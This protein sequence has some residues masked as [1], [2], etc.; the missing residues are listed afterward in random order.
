MWRTLGGRR[1][2]ELDA[3]QRR[4]GDPLCPTRLRDP[5]KDEGLCL[6]APRAPDL[7]GPGAPHDGQ[8]GL[9]G[10]EAVL[11]PPCSVSVRIDGVSLQPGKQLVVV[12]QALAEM[13]SYGQMTRLQHLDPLRR[14]V[15][16]A[17]E[18]FND[19]T[20]QV[21]RLKEYKEDGTALGL[22]LP[23]RALSVD[24]SAASPEPAALSWPVLRGPLEGAGRLLRV[25]H[26]S[27][28]GGAAAAG[29]GHRGCRGW[30]IP[31]PGAPGGGSDGARARSPED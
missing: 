20:R 28:C 19:N 14:R 2:E 27:S 8:A 5:N 24:N 23:G 29:A 21:F 26:C 4:R 1:A 25:Y 15:A 31:R 10:R 30:Q 3:G 12:R 7:L 22:D 11:R 16:P 13:T 9:C 17:L 6:A 18:R